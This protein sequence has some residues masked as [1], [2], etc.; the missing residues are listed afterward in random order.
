MKSTLLI[1]IISSLSSIAL[2]AIDKKGDPGPSQRAEAML[3]HSDKNNDGSINLPEFINSKIGKSITEDKGA[4]AVGKIF[5][6]ADKNK[7]G[8]LNRGELA[9]MGNN[10]AKGGARKNKRGK[11]KSKGK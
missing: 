2:L 6:N 9:H 7:D 10:K 4:E 1:I 3:K 11:G 5:A 8:E